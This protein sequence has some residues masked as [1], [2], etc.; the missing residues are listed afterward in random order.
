[1]PCL[2][3]ACVALLAVLS[4]QAQGRTLQAR[5]AKVSTP[6]A[7]LEQVRVRLDWPADATEGELTLQVAA[8]DAADLGY[9]WRHVSWHCPLQRTGPDSWR[10][11]GVPN[12]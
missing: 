8:V 11:D 2:R 6:V 9:R 3:L 4:M 12:T 5:I 7:T 10:C 1:M